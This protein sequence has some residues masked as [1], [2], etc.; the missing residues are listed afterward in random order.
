MRALG[1]RLRQIFL[2]L[3]RIRTNN[4]FVL[5][6]LVCG[7]QLCFLLAGLIGFAQWVGDDLQQRLLQQAHASDEQ[8]VA[9]LVESIRGLKLK[10]LKPDDAGWLGVQTIVE[11]TRLP[12]DGCVCVI[13]GENG[14]IICHPDARSDNRLLSVPLGLNTLH[15]S[16]DSPSVILDAAHGE[17]SA[18]GWVDMPDGRHLVAVRNVPELNIRVL[19]LQ[20]ERA[21]TQ[22]TASLDRGARTAALAF[23]AL[24]ITGTAGLTLLIMQRYEHRLSDL[25]KGLELQVERRSR[26]LLRARDAVIFGL[27][28]LAE[29]RHESTGEHLTRIGKYVE[30]LARQLARRDA[31]IGE[32]LIHTIV[33]ASS[34]HDIGK[35]A[36]PDSVLLKPGKLTPRQRVVMRQHTIIGGE[37][38]RAIKQRL[39]EDD[40]LA[41]ACEIALSHHERWNGEGYPNGLSGQEIPFTAR[42]VALAD[43]YDALTSERVYKQAMSHAEARDM[44]ARGSGRQFDPCVVEA[45]L[46]I[47]HEFAHI[48]AE[49]QANLFTRAAA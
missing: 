5:L 46:A 11:Q 29:S 45:F 33:V 7:G 43:V 37:C 49:S 19:A 25:N 12:N 14:H 4:R 39:G 48:A 23:A 38:L 22:V 13:E 16:H 9:R 28:H 17:H 6:A 44:I 36:I 42:I 47:E 3:A 35:V 2:L 34:L 8:A 32:Q 27:A 41:I 31:A 18:T 21:I 26:A 24:V 15:T 1:L 40:F 10:N 20:P 30:S